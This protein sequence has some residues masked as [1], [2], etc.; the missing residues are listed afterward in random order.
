MSATSLYMSVAG[1]TLRPSGALH[2]QWHS[3]ASSSD[4]EY[5]YLRQ[6]AWAA[7]DPIVGDNTRV[8]LQSV[9]ENGEVCIE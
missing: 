9:R 5:M 7:L 2:Q 8:M 1:A 3:N 4:L 6:G